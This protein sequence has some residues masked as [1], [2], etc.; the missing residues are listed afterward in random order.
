M[1]RVFAGVAAS[2]ALAASTCSLR[3]PSV[4]S[5][6]AQ[7]FPE[8]LSEWHL[9]AGRARDLKPNRGVVPYDINT[10]LFSDYADKHRFVW[11]PAGAAAV[12]NP[13][14]VFDFPVGTIFSKTF[15]YPIDGQPGVERL[16]ETRLLVHSDSGWVGLPYVWND[17]Q[18]EATLQLDADPTVVHWTAPSGRPYTI[19]YQIPNANQCKECHNRS[20]VM[21][22]LGPKARNLNKPYPYPEGAENELAHWTRVGYLRGAPAPSVA[23]RT[24]VWNHP[25][26]GSPEARARA[27]LDVNCGTCHSPRGSANNTGLDLTIA[28]TDPVRLGVCKVPVAAGQGSGDLLLDVIP[29]RP[30]ASILLHRM[31][32]TAPKVMMPELGRTV[33]HEEGVELVREWIASLQGNCGPRAVE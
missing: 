21:V 8:K 27:Y 13:D 6:T 2:A 32:S 14:E 9:F 25:A 15:A 16:I 17:A 19:N 3:H 29:Q 23:P 24:A 31:E 10:P 33:T 12:Y 1:G 26:S 28:E 22:P 30:E 5:Y 20:K 11:M 7:P 4:H 18:T